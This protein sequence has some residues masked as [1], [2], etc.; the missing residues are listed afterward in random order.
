MKQ[1]FAINVQKC[2]DFYHPEDEGGLTWNDPEIGIAWPQVV[3]Q[4]SGSGSAEG[5]RLEDGSE[6]KLSEKDQKWAKL[7]FYKTK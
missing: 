6:L 7:E 1:S 4:Y 2:T 5:Y 3:G